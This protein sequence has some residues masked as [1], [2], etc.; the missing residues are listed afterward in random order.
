MAGVYHS[1]KLRAADARGLLKPVDKPSMRQGTILE[2][3]RRNG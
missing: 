2:F 3:L 1:G